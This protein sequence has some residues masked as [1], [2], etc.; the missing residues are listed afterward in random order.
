MLIKIISKFSCYLIFIY[1]NDYYGKLVEDFIVLFLGLWGGDF[2]VLF[3][4]Y[5]NEFIGCCYL[6]MK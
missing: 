6:L 1:R 2:D 4:L 5:Y 3:Y